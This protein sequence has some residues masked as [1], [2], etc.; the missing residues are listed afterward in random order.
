VVSI[1][2][3]ILGKP[4]STEEAIAMLGLLS[5]NIHTVYTGYSIIQKKSGI[6]VTRHCATEVY[7]R[8]LEDSEI[9]DYVDGGSPMDKAGSYGIQDDLG[10]VFVEKI[11][12]DYFNVV[13]LPLSMVY[14]DLKKFSW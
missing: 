11:H 7:F 13:G 8:R 1:N 2:N 5:D 9:K 3:Q 6:K 12:G 4:N 14:T 10:A